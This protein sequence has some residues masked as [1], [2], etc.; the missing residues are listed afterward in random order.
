VAFKAVFFSA[1]ATGAA[2]VAIGKVLSSSAA[3]LCSS[4]IRVDVPR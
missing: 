1:G 4:R 3:V 2:G